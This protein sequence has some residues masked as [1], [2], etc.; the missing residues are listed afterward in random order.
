MRWSRAAFALRAAL[1]LLVD[2][3]GIASFGR[4]VGRTRCRAIN[5]DLTMRVGVIGDTVGIVPKR[6][7]RVA[8]GLGAVAASDL[9]VRASG[10]A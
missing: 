2:A 7:S 10:A 5:V 6:H 9:G 8:S 3:T 4:G 1:L